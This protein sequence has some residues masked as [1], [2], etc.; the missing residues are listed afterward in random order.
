MLKW[1]LPS[2]REREGKKT[3]QARENE[4]M[5]LRHW[6]PEARLSM[7]VN[8]DHK[9][10]NTRIKKE[11]VGHYLTEDIEY[12]VHDCMWEDC[13]KTSYLSLCYHFCPVF[14]N[15]ILASSPDG[16]VG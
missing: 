1:P 14:R 3:I 4:L 16:K 12:K 10:H 8:R 13:V 5:L 11:T 15:I 6:A 9:N 2:P 7:N